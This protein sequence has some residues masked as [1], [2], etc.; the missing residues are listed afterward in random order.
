MKLRVQ[1]LEKK[2][3]RGE[4]GDKRR[5]KVKKYDYRSKGVRGRTKKGSEI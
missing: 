3:I 2:G 5:K 4:E 1:H